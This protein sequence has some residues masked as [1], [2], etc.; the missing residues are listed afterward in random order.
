ML[1]LQFVLDFTILTKKITEFHLI[2]FDWYFFIVSKFTVIIWNKN[3]FQS[4][5]DEVSAQFSLGMI[6]GKVRASGV[7]TLASE[8]HQFE[9]EPCKN[10]EADNCYLWKKVQAKIK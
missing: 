6:N 8:D 5:D 3:I 10:S 1:V 9:L 7:V 4:S 2:K